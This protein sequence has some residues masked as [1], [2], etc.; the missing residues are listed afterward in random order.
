MYNDLGVTPAAPHAQQHRKG[1]RR[2]GKL[3]SSCVLL[4]RQPLGNAHGLDER[5]AQNLQAITSAALLQAPQLAPSTVPSGSTLDQA[6]ATW[7]G[8]TKEPGGACR[9]QVRRL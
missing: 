8:G 7:R 3:R 5:H 2:F 6:T 9:L 4:D 1:K